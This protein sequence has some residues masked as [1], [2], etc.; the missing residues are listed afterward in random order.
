MLT[1]VKEIREFL[2]ALVGKSSQGYF[3]SVLGFTRDAQNLA[4]QH[5]IKLI[6]REEILKDINE[7][8]DNILR[9]ITTKIFSR[10]YNIPTCPNCLTKMVERQGK[11]KFWGCESY[12]RCKQKMQM[13]GSFN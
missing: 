8:N 10:G 5:N 11:T 1:T 9:P 3:F 12:P 6:S 7:L 2:G 13:R 4:T